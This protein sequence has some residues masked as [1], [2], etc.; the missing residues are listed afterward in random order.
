MSLIIYLRM[1]QELQVRIRPAKNLAGPYFKIIAWDTDY[2]LIE[3]GVIFF[4]SGMTPINWLK[5]LEC[6]DI[7]GIVGGG[8]V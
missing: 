4:L 8:Y 2:L 3:I 6:R 1:F 7:I 5:K